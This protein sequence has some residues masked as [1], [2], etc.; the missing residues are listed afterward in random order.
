MRCVMR[1]APP[2]L[3]RLIETFWYWKGDPLEHLKDTIPAS[4]G[5]DLLVNLADDHL[6]W[7]QG[8]DFRTAHSVSGIGLAGPS[9]RAIAVDAF[10]REMMGVKFRPGGA[11]PFFGVPIS[12]LA[13]RRV[14]LVELW[15]SDADRLREL[16]VDAPTPNEKF[17][18]LLHA[19]TARAR[20]FEC[21]P[22]VSHALEIFKRRYRA[23]VPV[24]AAE[25]GLSQKMF[26]KVFSEQVGFRPKLY[27][28]IARFQRVLGQIAQAQDV[29]WGDVFEQNGYY[30]QSHFINDFGAFSGI[31]PCVYLNRRGPHLQHVPLPG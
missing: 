21:G 27:L 23:S 13:D 18:L 28:R 2:P 31:S 12:A 22:A 19:L 3:D 8:A 16:L 15:G 6:R 25:T 30:D 17:D 11:F 9:S 14:S 10:Q 29:D 7:Y 24:V 26:I 20:A 1:S 5:V 4:A